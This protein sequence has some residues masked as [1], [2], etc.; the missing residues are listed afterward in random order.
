MIQARYLK[1]SLLSGLVIFCTMLLTSTEVLAQITPAPASI[2]HQ[3]P[4]STSS[5]PDTKK[6]SITPSH[7]PSTVSDVQDTT[8]SEEQTTITENTEPDPTESLVDTITNQVNEVLSA[9]G[10]GLGS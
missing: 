10:I 9:A 7:N 8:P 3:S 2:D 6:S 5:S 4:S 1:Y